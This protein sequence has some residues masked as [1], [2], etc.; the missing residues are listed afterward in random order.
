MSRL[1]LSRTRC[2]RLIPRS[3]EKGVFVALLGPSGWGRTTLLNIVAGLAHAGRGRLV[4]DGEDIT[5]QPAGQRRFGMVFQS[6][7]LFRHMTVAQNIGFDL[8]G[9]KNG[10]DRAGIAQRVGDLPGMIELPGLG[11][12]YPAQLSGGQRQRVAMARALAIRPRLLLRD[13]PFSAL[14]AQVRESQRS[15]VRALQRK[16]GVGAIMVTHDRGEAEALAD[17][18]AIMDHGRILCIDRPA[19]AAA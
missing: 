13:E 7:A 6:Y 19:A 14:D 11:D 9:M 1:T 5:R 18:I 15:E 8:K 2:L 16:A 10:P 4:F 12:R 17:R 3:L